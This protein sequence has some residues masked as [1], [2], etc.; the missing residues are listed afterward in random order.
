MD[1]NKAKLLLESDG[2]EVKLDVISKLKEKLE[3]MDFRTEIDDSDCY[4]ENSGNCS[5]ICFRLGKDKCLV[6][7]FEKFEKF[8]YYSLC[9]TYYNLD[10]EDEMSEY[11]FK[12][13]RQKFSRCRHYDV[14][15]FNLNDV[16]TDFEFIS[17][18]IKDEFK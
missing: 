4:A 15:D 13:I 14:K 10:F 8:D 1:Y 18:F 16:F 9:F 11:G 6:G 2:Y 7:Y 5:R 3:S 12:K 17:S